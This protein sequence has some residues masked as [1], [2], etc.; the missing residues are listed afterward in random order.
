MFLGYFGSGPVSLHILIPRSGCV[1]GESIPLQVMVSNNSSVTV[2]KV[3]F[4]LLKIIDYYSKTP[5]RNTTQEILKIMKKEA[6]GVEKK[7]EQRYEHSLEIPNLPST[8]K[9]YSGLINISYEIRVE[10]KIAG[11]FKNLIESIPLTVG[12]VGI[13]DTDTASLCSLPMGRIQMP[14]PHYP[15]APPTSND[16][17][18][19]SLDTS[20]ISL[21][22]LENNLPTT[23][24]CLPPYTSRMYAT[25][26]T[27]NGQQNTSTPYPPPRNRGG[28]G[29]G[30]VDIGFRT[31][32]PTA[33]PLDFTF[34]SPN[35]TRSSI[36]SQQWDTPPTYDEV[37]GSPA[38]A[39]ASSHNSTAGDSTIPD[40]TPVAS[41][42]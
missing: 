12:T 27:T 24:T 13:Y 15:V 16:L 6:P 33:P 28:G 32:L 8:D 23:D 41:F 20:Q 21:N 3:K 38:H 14:M 9:E 39:M 7:S 10:A 22:S 40:K 17:P 19:P 11:L 35:S 4:T 26:Q 29:A 5:S 37:F 42:T 36:C 34:G 31:N 18:Y 2:D 1:R 30:G 25:D